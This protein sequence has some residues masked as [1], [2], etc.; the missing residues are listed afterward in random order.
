[1]RAPVKKALHS[2]FGAHFVSYHI[3]IV[4]LYVLTWVKINQYINH[5]LDKAKRAV[6]LFGNQTPHASVFLSQ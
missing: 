2:F 1:M 4:T 5:S 6:G 3:V